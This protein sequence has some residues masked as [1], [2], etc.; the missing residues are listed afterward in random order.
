M[1]LNGTDENA[2]PFLIPGL[3][4]F[5]D[6]KATTRPGNLYTEKLNT[7]FHND[8]KS[9]YHIP[10]VP[11]GVPENRRLKVITIGAGL[12]GVMLAYNIEKHTP[13]VEHVIYEKN[14]EVGGTWVS[15]SLRDSACCSNSDTYKMTRSIKTD[16][17]WPVV[18]R[19]HA[20]ISSTLPF[21]L[22]SALPPVETA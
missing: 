10:F 2:S 19:R 17:P 22:V 9:G 13:N 8:A 1:A 18:T 15:R 6:P 3:K 5:S 21:L 11:V 12:C 20:R 7:D 14:P 4:F 16:T